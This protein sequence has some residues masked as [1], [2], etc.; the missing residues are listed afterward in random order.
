MREIEAS[1]QQFADFLLKAQLVKEQAAP[2]CV[3]WVR[4]FLTRP[5][6]NEPL[7]GSRRRV[8]VPRRTGALVPYRAATPTGCGASS[9]T[10]PSGRPSRTPASRPRRH[11][12]I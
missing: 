9:R 8:P 2:Y 12:T 6:A 3:R 7:A 11:A 10:S 5:A 1:L 4:R